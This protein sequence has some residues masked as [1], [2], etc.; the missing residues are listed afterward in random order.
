MKTVSF[1]ISSMFS[2]SQFNGDISKWNVSG[3]KDMS[4][5]FYGSEFN[6]DISNWDVSNVT[7]VTDMFKN[8]ALE[9]SGNI[10]DWYYKK[11]KELRAKEDWPGED[12]DPEE[13]YDLEE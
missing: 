5:M 11:S 10:P 4:S 7:D 13:E 12:F 1:A 3:V 8:S 2:Q 6:G 9:R